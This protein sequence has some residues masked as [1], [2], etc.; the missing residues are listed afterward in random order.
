MSSNPLS[1]KHAQPAVASEAVLDV[2]V[3]SARTAVASWSATPLAMRQAML[4]T[5]AEALERNPE[6]IAQE[7]T[8]EQETGGRMLKQNLQPAALDCGTLRN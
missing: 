4:I 6:R 2:A 5:L 7:R 1:M 8:A 3:C